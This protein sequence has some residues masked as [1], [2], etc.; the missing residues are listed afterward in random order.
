LQKWDILGRASS[1]QT[2]Q[3]QKVQPHENEHRTPHRT[4]GTRGESKRMHMKS[5]KG[6]VQVGDG[7]VQSLSFVG[8][9]GCLLPNATAT[10][11]SRCLESEAE[12]LQ[13]I[14]ILTLIYIS[15][16]PRRR[17]LRAPWKARC[18]MRGRGQIRQIVGNFY[19][20][21]QGGISKI[22]FLFIGSR[23]TIRGLRLPEE[24]PRCL[25]SRSC[26]TERCKRDDNRWW[27]KRCFCLTE[28]IY[29]VYM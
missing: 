25:R 26:I 7:S 12:V 29:S 24:S 13:D 14:S 22:H 28:R 16:P 10:S 23:G 19:F 6:D 9:A 27:Q 2:S 1:H 17:N 8:L 11:L 3:N 18:D 4:L 15:R 20:C 21:S 5:M